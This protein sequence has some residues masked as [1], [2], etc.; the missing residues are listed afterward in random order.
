MN[1][2][3]CWVFSILAL[4]LGAVLAAALHI[5]ILLSL[6]FNPVT[7]ALVALAAAAAF[8]EVTRGR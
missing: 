4:L 2:M 7:I 1:A 3:G 8:S 5:D 6:L